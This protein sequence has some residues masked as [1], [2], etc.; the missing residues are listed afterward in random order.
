MGHFRIFNQMLVF[1]TAKNILVVTLQLYRLAVIIL[2]F[3]ATILQKSRKGEVCCCPCEPY[4]ASTHATTDQDTEMKD[5]AASPSKEQ[6][7]APPEDQWAQLLTWKRLHFPQLLQKGLA[8]F[9]DQTQP[10]RVPK[11]SLPPRD[12]QFLLNCRRN[13]W[14]KTIEIGHFCITLYAGFLLIPCYIIHRDFVAIV[15]SSTKVLAH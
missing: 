1:F 12:Q 13:F 15:C 2:D 5:F 4:N 11:S 14:S 6:S 7:Q 10:E 8:C 3:R 9:Y